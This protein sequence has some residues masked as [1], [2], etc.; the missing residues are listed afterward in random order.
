MKFIYFLFLVPMLS[1]CQTP[2]PN[3][4]L[5]YLNKAKEVYPSLKLSST[6]ETIKD[7]YKLIYDDKTY[8]LTIDNDNVITIISVEPKVGDVI[9]KIYN[10][11]NVFTKFRTTKLNGKYSVVLHKG[12]QQI[13][14]ANSPKE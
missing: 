14:M 11:N 6:C 7:G 8:S 1:F 13:Y 2:T 9:E 12:K 5:E 4:V 10:I 3:N